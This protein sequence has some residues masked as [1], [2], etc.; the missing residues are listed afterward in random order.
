MNVRPKK[1][2]GQH[3]LTDLNI[4][5]NIADTL[6][7]DGYKHVLEVGPGMGVLTQY[8][9][10]KPFT[11]HVIEIDTESVSYLKT[12]FSQLENR[13]L[14]GDFLKIS[15]ANQFDAQVAV[16]GNFPYNISSQIL[17]RVIE[18]RTQVPEFAGMARRPIDGGIAS[19]PRPQGNATWR[20]SSPTTS[21]ALTPSPCAS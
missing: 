3:F 10:E 15:L 19:H 7:G 21:S 18:Q 13:I 2:L 14:E 4:A 9:L 12:H 8:L 17:F 6:S 20:S 5:Q 16:I 11:T 1:Y